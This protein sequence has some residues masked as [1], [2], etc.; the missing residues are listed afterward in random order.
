MTIKDAVKRIM[1][2]S[3]NTNRAKVH[4]R[5]KQLVGAGVSVEDAFNGLDVVVR[6]EGLNGRKGGGDPTAQEAMAR[7]ETDIRE[8]HGYMTNWVTR[9]G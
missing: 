6:T 3:P 7:M 4:N 9:W 2:N 1:A 5:L 8:E